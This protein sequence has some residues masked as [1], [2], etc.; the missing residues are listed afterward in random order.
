MDREKQGLLSRRDWLKYTALSSAAVAA[1]GR[2]AW[3][4]V[5]ADQTP[6]EI[7]EV[8]NTGCGVREDMPVSPLILE[9]WKDDLPLPKAMAPGWRRVDGTHAPEAPDAWT[10]RPYA[11]RP[12]GGVVVPS[13]DSGCQDAMG[14]R[15]RGDNLPHAGTHQLWPGTPGT[16]CQNYPA[17]IYYHIRLQVA[18]HRVTSSLV[19]P[20]VTGS[21]IPS[22]DRPLPAS[23]IYGYN[24][25]FA[26]A[27]IN[28]EYGRPV[29]LRFEN[30]LDLNPQCLDRQN[31]GAPDWAFLTHLHNGHTAPESDGN[32]NHLTENE[33][34]YHPAEWCDNLYL[35]YPA[36]GDDREKQSFLWFHDHRM[37]H[38]GA[39]V[40]KG[41]LGL[42]PHYDPKI[43]SGDERTGLRLPGV[44]R[45]NPD[46][47]FDVDYDIPLALYD[48]ALDD[49]KVRHQDQHIPKGSLCDKSHPE[50][51]GK[52][53][54]RHQ[55]NHGFVGDIFTVNGKAFPV[56]R[57][58]RRRYRLRFLGASIARCYELALMQGQ[59]GAFPG[60]QGQWNFV[61]SSGGG[62]TRSRGQ[63]CM[64]FT[65]IASEG[66]L[67]PT[68]IV[69]NT[70]QIWPAKRREFVVDFGHYMDGRSTSLGDVIYLA[71]VLQMPDGRKPV[72]NGE[73]EFDD[74]YCVPML[75]IIIDG[76]AED[77]SV[78]PVPGQTLRPMPPYLPTAV[79][80]KARFLLSRGGTD[81][82]GQWVIN[83]L[84][85][86]PTR[87]LHK[88][89][90]NSAEEWTVENGGGGWTHPLHM[91][92]EEHRVLSRSAS[93]N[94]HPDDTG[95]E[96]VIALDPGESVRIYRRF[97]TF[98]GCYVAHC[99][100]LA[101]ED[102][103]MM[104]G[105]VI[106]P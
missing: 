3:A 89:K 80:Q 29:C 22:G 53:F 102:H 78:M 47:T 20:L 98:A 48:C 82:E 30:D 38:T 105:W 14:D 25:T 37:H 60:Q 44:R 103:N 11:G 104:F 32:P 42:M 88:V 61:T 9:P 40:Y 26:G 66:G 67:L 91:H 43:D 7:H 96:D 75:K 101:H 13:K 86:D 10:C 54:F 62:F 21:G 50:W 97:R 41:M 55:A 69:R 35:M 49:G 57:V 77:N 92:Q 28:A 94:A 59:I 74:K 65:Q 12:N 39:N 33:G 36:G 19:R 70:F 56:L 76:D 68:A 27:L 31:F 6:I 5:C 16:A 83:G 95:K 8:E 93:T 87:P 72:F 85:F 79:R 58:K 17:P 52:L 1:A 100:N 90:M 46:G 64:R 51:W 99:H 73:G 45:N 4:A 2:T 34:G 24:G 23:T 71:N 81:D 106:E 15:T 84:G 18:E 63:Q